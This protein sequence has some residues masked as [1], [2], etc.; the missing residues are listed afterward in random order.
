MLNSHDNISS[1][2]VV[3]Q[4]GHVRLHEVSIPPPQSGKQNKRTSQNSRMNCL[5]MPQG[6]APGL[7]SLDTARALKSPR[8]RPCERCQSLFHNK[9]N[10]SISSR[11]LQMR[12]RGGETP[13]PSLEMCFNLSSSIPS[14][15]PACL[16]RG[17][18]KSHATL[19]TK[20]M[21]THIDYGRSQGRPLG[22]CAYGVCGI[23]DVCA[24]DDL[25]ASGE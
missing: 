11:E 10:I 17:S 7:I 16:G 23:L 22:T 9:D 4:D 14:T 3:H 15:S 20:N 2:A 18:A 1:L 19:L 6:L 21:N 8:L 24:L 25:A 12:M 13:P 5:H